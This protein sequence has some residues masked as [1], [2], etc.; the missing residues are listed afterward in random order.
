MTTEKGTLVITFSCSITRKTL[1]VAYP[2][3]YIC[4]QHSLSLSCLSL[5][6]FSVLLLLFQC[7]FNF[8]LCV[9]KHKG[10]A[11]KLKQGL[12]V[13]ALCN[14]KCTVSERV[15]CNI[16]LGKVGSCVSSLPLIFST[17]IFPTSLFFF[18]FFL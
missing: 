11:C 5:S 15:L 6:L 3:T 9:N 13:S 1:I 4:T 16:D 17:I 7:L 2:F 12:C 10:F 8:N 18:F 14:N